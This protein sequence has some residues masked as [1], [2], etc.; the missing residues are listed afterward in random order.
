MATIPYSKRERCNKA[1]V[2]CCFFGVVVKQ[3]G[4][5]LML[6]CDLILIAVLNMTHVIK[7]PEKKTLKA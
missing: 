6:L 7:M 5:Y 1:S 4:F 2:S 3:I